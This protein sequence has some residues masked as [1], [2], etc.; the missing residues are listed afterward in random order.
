[1]E[2]DIYAGYAGEMGKLSY[3]VGILEFMYPPNSDNN[4]AE[5]HLTLGYD[6]DVVAVSGTFYGGING[7]NDAD[8]DTW[9][10]SVSIP[11]PVMDISLD[12]TYGDYMDYNKYTTVGLSKSFK[13]FDVNVMYAYADFDDGSQSENNVVLTIGTSF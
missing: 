2:M 11:L 6:F 1:M 9:E 3:D 4:F 8:S 13:K 12:A 5:A 10:A 7:T